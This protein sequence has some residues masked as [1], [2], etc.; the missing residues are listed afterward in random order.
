[1]A[2]VATMLAE[3]APCIA[4]DA[5]ER[6]V[7]EAQK[8]SGGRCDSHDG[9]LGDAQE[10]SAFE[11]YQCYDTDEIS[12]DEA[13]EGSAAKPGGTAEAEQPLQARF[14]RSCDA[15]KELGPAIDGAD[16]LYLYGRFKQAQCGDCG[17]ERPGMFAGVLAR[18]KWDAWN[19]A[20][21]H[22][23]EQA[24]EDYIAKVR[25]IEQANC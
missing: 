11:G 25:E 23:A 17:N 1:M 22:S 19:A 4:A 18:A 24:M 3:A 7:P 8:T 21:G 15:V 10:Y 16:G 13:P 20:R 14:S 9:D 2:A 12:D 5:E 6:K